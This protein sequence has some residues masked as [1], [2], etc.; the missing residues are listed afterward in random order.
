M[1]QISA[2]AESN[3]EQ[4]R[5]KDGKFGEQ[6]HDKADGITLTAP[7]PG[8]PIPGDRGQ[9]TYTADDLDG[10]PEDCELSISDYGDGT[11]GVNYS[12][13]LPAMD[14][15]PEDARFI[16]AASHGDFDIYQSHTGEI[17]MEAERDNVPRTDAPTAED[18]AEHAAADRMNQLDE[19]TIRDAAQGARQTAELQAEASTR[20]ALE[21][22]Y[23]Q[24][25][26]DPDVPEDFDWSTFDTSDVEQELREDITQTLADNWDRIERIAAWRKNNLTDDQR[27]TLQQF[28]VRNFDNTI[29]VAEEVAN[30]RAFGSD[31]SRLFSEN[32]SGPDAHDIDVRPRETSP[33]IADDGSLIVE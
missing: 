20:L 14:L 12:R 13:V 19:D 15:D 22:M 26:D 5:R 32:W 25:E 4:A 3:R 10:Y 7:R 9:A 28:D 21:S 24:L 11:M 18:A 27:D 16:A 29:G 33:A 30:Y 31:V 23:R 8:Q 2:S 1:N 6:Q 17:R